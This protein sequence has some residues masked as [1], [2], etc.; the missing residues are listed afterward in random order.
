MSEQTITK[1]YIDELSEFLKD[2][3][4]HFEGSVLVLPEHIRASD[5]VISY[6]LERNIKIKHEQSEL[7]SSYYNKQVGLIYPDKI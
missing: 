2:R 6:A 4:L 1:E 7:M 3:R 5:E